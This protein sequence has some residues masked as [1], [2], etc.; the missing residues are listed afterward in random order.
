MTLGSFPH[1]FPVP[2]LL[3]HSLKEQSWS[4]QS[5]HHCVRLFIGQWAL[6]KDHSQQHP[7]CWL[8]SVP[9]RIRGFSAR[10]NTVLCV[11]VLQL[12]LLSPWCTCE[13]VFGCERKCQKLCV[14]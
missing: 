1:S 8:E 10:D 9:K 13:S 6:L 11:T 5:C 3:P 14:P 2:V 12:S 7:Q 4:L